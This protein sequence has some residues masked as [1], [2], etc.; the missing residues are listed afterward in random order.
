[1]YLFYSD[2]RS[3]HAVDYISVLWVDHLS[4][5]EWISN[6]KIFLIIYQ[7]KLTKCDTWWC[8]DDELQ[9]L[10]FY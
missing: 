3:D 5:M 1:M 9:S 8:D 10:M 4:D 7:K 2:F 6:S